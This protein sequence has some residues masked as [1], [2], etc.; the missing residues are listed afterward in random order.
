MA[1]RSPTIA[2][3]IQ[4]TPQPRASKMSEKQQSED[5]RSTLTFPRSTRVDSQRA[6]ALEPFAASKRD[7]NTRKA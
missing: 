1:A 5:E 2:N 3:H 7:Q 4:T 6:R